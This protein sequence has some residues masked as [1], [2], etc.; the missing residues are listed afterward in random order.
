MTDV[1]AESNIPKDEQQTER[2]RL[3]INKLCLINFKSFAGTQ[4]IGPF[5]KVSTRRFLEIH[6]QTTTSH[7]PL[8]LVQMVAVKVIQLT[9]Y[10][11]FSVIVHP[12]CVN[13]SSQS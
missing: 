3:V 12:R 2:S 1:L 7:S 11:S 6:N 10:S 13:R 4:V 5:H 8:S 9:R